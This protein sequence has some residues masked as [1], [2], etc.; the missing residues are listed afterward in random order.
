MA[1]SNKTELAMQVMLD[2]EDEV[3]TDALMIT[4]RFCTSPHIAKGVTFI[5]LV[6]FST[7][8]KLPKAIIVVLIDSECMVSISWKDIPNLK[9]GPRL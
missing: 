2:I 5:N 6:H 4:W 1:T 7:N 3:N 8:E 9:V